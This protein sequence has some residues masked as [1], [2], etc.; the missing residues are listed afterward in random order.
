MSPS[1]LLW[2]VRTL[3]CLGG[4]LHA[5]EMQM[6]NNVVT[7]AAVLAAYTELLSAALATPLLVGQEGVADAAMAENGASPPAQLR[8]PAV[9]P[10]Q[11]RADFL[12]FCVL[13]ALPFG[14]PQL[15]KVSTPARTP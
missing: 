9:S 12:V 10:N 6:C 4:P 2:W 14:A 7:P 11:P 1:V 8:S 3:L 13:A 15:H 5:A